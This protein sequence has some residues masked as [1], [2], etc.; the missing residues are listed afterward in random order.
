MV[1]ILVFAVALALYP[2]LTRVAGFLTLGHT[3]YLYLDSIH[4]NLVGSHWIVLTWFVMRRPF[5]FTTFGLFVY[6]LPVIY[7]SVCATSVWFM[8]IPPTTM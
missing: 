7:W 6:L 4:V 1:K 5:L 8:S 2:A 3:Y